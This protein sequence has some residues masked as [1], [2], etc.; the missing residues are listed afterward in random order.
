MTLSFRD[1]AHTA[2]SGSIWS[3]LLIG[4]AIAA[5]YMSSATA[6]Q[7]PTATP[8]PSLKGIM[9][10]QIPLDLANFNYEA[11]GPNWEEFSTQ[12]QDALFSLYAP[13]NDAQMEEALDSLKRKLN[14]IDKA[15]KDSRYSSIEDT[16]LDLRGKIKRRLDLID[17]VKQLLSGDY[18]ANSEDPLAHNVDVVKNETIRLNNDLNRVRGGNAWISYLNLSSVQEDLDQGNRDQ[19]IV[20]TASLLNKIEPSSV[21]GDEQAQF[22]KRESFERTRE[23]ITNLITVSNVQSQPAGPDDAVR[24]LLKELFEATESYEANKLTTSADRIRQTSSKI[25]AA[26]SPSNPVTNFVNSNYLNY[27]FR[28]QISEGFLQS[29]ANT[30][31]TDCGPVRDCILGASVYGNQKTT[32]DLGVNLLPDASEAKI[33]LTLT[34]NVNTNTTAYKDKAVIY[35]TGHSNFTGSKVIYYNGSRFASEQAHLDVRSSTR[36]Y[37]AKVNIFLLGRL[38]EGY[39]LRQAQSKTPQSNAISASRVRNRVLPRFNEDTE[40]EFAEAQQKIDDKFYAPLREEQLF[41]QDLDFSTT[42]TELKINARLMESN[43]VGADR[44]TIDYQSGN[45]IVMQIH[46]SWINN[47]LDRMDLRN[48]TM[49]STELRQEFQIHFEKILGRPVDLEKNSQPEED[50]AKLVFTD[51][52]PIRVKI[53]KNTINLVLRAGLQQPDKEPIP[54]QVVTVPMMISKSGNKI[55]L[56]RGDVEVAPLE[57]PD[58]VTEQIARAGVMRNRIQ[59]SIPGS[60][61]ET[62]KVITVGNSQKTVTVTSLT[63]ADGWLAALAQ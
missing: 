10:E 22:L 25:A 51:V 45:G 8:G 19:I 11:L 6:L 56:E 31:R 61:L 13:E 35:S 63:A 14:V 38:F 15:L 23:A 26:T 57:Q 30:N 58:N 32:T 50:G 46:E 43:E 3:L 2:R 28:I 17:A 21:A 33:A 54:T 5:G 40:R 9:V 39:A 55:L 1:I 48:R 59:D 60:E 41:P 34:G 53:T 20:S 49:T 36:P 47:A 4:G 18:Q 12:T 7:D 44:P 29:L 62:T 42:N 24:G 16:L 27:N 37:A 52:D